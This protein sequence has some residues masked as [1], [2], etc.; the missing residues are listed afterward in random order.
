MPHSP[1]SAGRTGWHFRVRASCSSCSHRPLLQQ[2][3]H[4]VTIKIVTQPVGKSWNQPW[5][6]TRAPALSG[7]GCKTPRAQKEDCCLQPRGCNVNHILE[8]RAALWVC[9]KLPLWG[10]LR[11]LKGT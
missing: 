1:R 3:G 9:R 11:G 7:A 5:V 6:R 8:G 4:V 2:T 10:L